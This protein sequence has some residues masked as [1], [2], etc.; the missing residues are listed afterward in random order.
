MV[1]DRAVAARMIGARCAGAGSCEVPAAAAAATRA[2][3][4]KPADLNINR[5]PKD[6]TTLGYRK[7]CHILAS[8]KFANF[9]LAASIRAAISLWAGHIPHCDP[10]LQRKRWCAHNLTLVLSLQTGGQDEHSQIRDSILAIS[11]VE[12]LPLFHGPAHNFVC[13]MSRGFQFQS[14]GYY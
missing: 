2:V 9:V 7:V 13:S 12:P 10:W 1:G 8:G 14:P 5:A 11:Q 4:A 6:L 3:A